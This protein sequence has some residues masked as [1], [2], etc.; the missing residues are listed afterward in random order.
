V[1]YITFFIRFDI[2]PSIEQTNKTNWIIFRT[3]Y[4]VTKNSQIR[5]KVNEVSLIL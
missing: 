2:R 1:F 3:E 4:S 5:N